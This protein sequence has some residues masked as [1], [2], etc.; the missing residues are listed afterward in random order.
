MAQ[1]CQNFPNLFA[2]GTLFDNYPFLLPNLICTII[3]AFG[4]LVGIL[5]LEETHESKRHQR[6]VGIE[7]GR[8]ALK[9]FSSKP[10]ANFASKSTKGN[11]ENQ[12]IPL[13]EDAPPGYRTTEGSPRHPSS[14]LQSPNILPTDLRLG[15]R[16]KAMNKPDGVRKAFTKQVLLNIVGFGLLA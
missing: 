16:R 6:D 5:F 11:V 12:G 15:G 8:W 7:I 13:E 1:P 2:R 4:V 14:R 10:E 3:L 9:V